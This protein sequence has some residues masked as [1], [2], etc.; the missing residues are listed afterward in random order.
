MPRI[1]NTEKVV[2][3]IRDLII[4]ACINLNDNTVQAIKSCLAKEESP[5]GRQV[6]E[7]LIANAAYA[8]EEHIA[9]CHDTGVGVVYMEIGQE[10][11]WTGKPLIDQ[12]NEG[13][14]QGYSEGYLRKSIVYD[15]V[16]NRVNTND[17]TPAV[18]HTE[19]VCGDKVHIAVLPKGGGSENMSRYKMLTPADGLEGVIEFIMETVEQAGGKPCPPYIVGIGI[20]GTMDQAAW[21]S[22]KSLF[23][24]IGERHKEK[25]YADFELELLDKVNKTGIGPLG[26]GGRMTA[27]DVHIE[28]QGC[29]ITSLPVAVNIQCHAARRS[30]AT[31]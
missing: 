7:E 19:I 13:V 11:S 17:N 4:D 18:V 2:P 30:Q 6:L 12:V 1:I 27:M 20:G 26:T 22:K 9:C 14:R 31:I 24:P 15:P 16:F 10:V 29:H 8:K 5:L 28:T 23:R 21:L 3:V 25:K